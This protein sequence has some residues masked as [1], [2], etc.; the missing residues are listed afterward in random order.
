LKEENLK[1]NYLTEEIER[2]KHLILHD[3][4]VSKSFDRAP[5][6]NK[7]MRN[8]KR[9][10][11]SKNSYSSRVKILL[12]CWSQGVSKSNLIFLRK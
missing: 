11:I 9:I 8:I 10:P 7:D 6:R 2:V 4:V 3:A 1:Q 5:N 12:V